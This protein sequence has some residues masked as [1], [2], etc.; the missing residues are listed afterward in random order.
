MLTDRE[1]TALRQVM[2]QAEG[3]EFDRHIRA[4]APGEPADRQ[5]TK[6]GR[7]EALLI[8]VLVLVAVIGV[9]VLIIAALL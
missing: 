8:G 2:E 4:R 1:A 6:R 9:L 3:E 7:G 5:G